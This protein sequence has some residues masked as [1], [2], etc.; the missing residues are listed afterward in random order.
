VS[1]GYR[2]VDTDDY[3]PREDEDYD[4]DD[5]HDYDHEPDEADME[6][7]AWRAGY[8]EHCEQAHGGNDCDCR[9]PLGERIRERFRSARRRV[10]RRRGRY[11]DDPPF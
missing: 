2:D 9:A 4:P 11:C 6:Y 7:D 5:F 10:V 8:E 3:D 1:D